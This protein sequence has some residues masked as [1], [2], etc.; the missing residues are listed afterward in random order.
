MKTQK[1]CQCKVCAIRSKTLQSLNEREN[2]YHEGKKL[3]KCDTCGFKSHFDI[4]M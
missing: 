3:F 4:A 2:S 1:K